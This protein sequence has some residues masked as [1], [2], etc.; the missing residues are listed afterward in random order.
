[1]GLSFLT[2]LGVDAHNLEPHPA[3]KHE[4]IALP[5]G[6]PATGPPPF[7]IDR[8]TTPAHT[9]S[10][11]KKAPDNFHLAL[12]GPYLGVGGLYASGYT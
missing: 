6:S 11:Q 7:V 1:M 2:G 3:G 4:H 9:P 12:F 5:P 10:T 8:S